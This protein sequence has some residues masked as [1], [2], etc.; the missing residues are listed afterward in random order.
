MLNR[1]FWEEAQGLRNKLLMYRLR[2]WRITE[3]REDLS[4]ASIE[5]RLDQVTLAL[6]TL[7]DDEEMRAQI[8]HF[9]R[10]YNATLIT[11]RQMSVPAVV[12]QVL[13]NTWYLPD[14]TLTGPRRDFTMKGL[15]QKVQE[16]LDELDP[17]ER[18]SPRRLGSLLSADLGLTRRTR[19]PETRRDALLIEEGELLALMARYG[20]DYPAAD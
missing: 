11:D 1:A 8:N 15:A 19:D 3:V 5:P 18:V 6:K 2:N 14:E 20:I 17:D 9:V 7:I 10:A 12:V 13:A 4:D 16:L